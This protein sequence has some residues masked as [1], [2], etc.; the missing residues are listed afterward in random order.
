MKKKMEGESL[1]EVT[2]RFE[3]SLFVSFDSPFFRPV[4]RL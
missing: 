2:V 4:F 3:V 1:S